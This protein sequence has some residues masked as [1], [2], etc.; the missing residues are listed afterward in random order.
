VP[1]AVVQQAV[2]ATAARVVGSA[3]GATVDLLEGVPRWLEDFRGPGTSLRETATWSPSDRAWIL[4]GSKTYEE[5]EASGT[6][7]YTYWVQFLAD[8]KPQHWVTDAII[9]QVGVVVDATISGSYHP[10][11]FE[12][13]HS[14]RAIVS[15][16]TTMND[17]GSTT[18]YGAG[19]FD[20]ATATRID[21][22]VFDHTQDVLWEYE[23]SAAPGA[24]CASGVL[25]G[26]WDSYAFEAT[27]DGAGGVAWW[28]DRGHTRL[29]T[30]TDSYPCTP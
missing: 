26:A 9:D 14:W 24:D 29:A 12:V 19:D 6:V 15:L 8:G 1:N 18:F 17:D 23:L 28:L 30:R 10:S 5:V 21:G 11:G 22:R 16:N 27:F 3:L 2:D 4:E 25:E 20:G 13:D 7:A